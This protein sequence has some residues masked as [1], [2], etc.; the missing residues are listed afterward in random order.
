MG[1]P[2]IFVIRH[3]E[4]EWN[5][6]GR[7]Q[8][9]LDSPLTDKGLA[10]AR[11]LGRML[12]EH[13]LSPD[14]HG[15]YSSPIRRARDTAAIALQEAGLEAGI[16]IE[17]ARLREISVGRWTGIHREVIRA[18]T[19]LS[20]NADFLEYYKATPEGERF[21][22]VMTRAKAFLATLEGP[23]VIFT[24]G[25][26]SRFLRLVALDWQA[27]RIGE[28]PGGQGVIHHIYNRQ[29]AELRP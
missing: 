11:D 28:L 15:F 23:S 2:E 4:T 29:F 13:G 3:G 27:E 20:E 19:G 6:S 8:G 10:Q 25:I 18:E 14:S 26:T 17:D 1:I 5:L 7:W 24:H 9:D 21:E 22:A 16:L 12:R